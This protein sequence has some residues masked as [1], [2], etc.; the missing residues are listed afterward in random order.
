VIHINLKQSRL[1][2]AWHVLRGRPIMYRMHLETKDILI[3]DQ[4]KA[5]GTFMPQIV[6][7]CRF[8]KVPG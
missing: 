8:E 2:L 4:L 5:D 7:E 6:Q 3:K 1:G